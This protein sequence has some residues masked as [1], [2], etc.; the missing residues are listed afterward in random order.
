MSKLGIYTEIDTN[1]FLKG[2]IGLQLH[3]LEDLVEQL[4]KIIAQKKAV[5]FQKQETKLLYLHN[6]TVL[7]TEEQEALKELIQKLEHETITK[8]ERVQ[9]TDLTTK[10]EILRNKRLQYLIEL[11]QIKQIPLPILMENLGLKPY[12]YE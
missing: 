8:R 1:T 10:A 5:R 12:G 7:P 9:L 4:T 6:T 3:D 2:A 11:A